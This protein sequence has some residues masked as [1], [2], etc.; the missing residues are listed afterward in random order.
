MAGIALL[1]SGRLVTYRNGT[2]TVHEPEHAEIENL[3][4]KVDAPEKHNDHKCTLT[5]NP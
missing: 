3:I 1:Q 4:A 2:L 5:I